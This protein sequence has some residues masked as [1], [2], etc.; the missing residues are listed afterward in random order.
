[1]IYS[2]TGT[3]DGMIFYLANL[4]LSMQF[5][6]L[7]ELDD[8]GIKIDNLNIPIPFEQGVQAYTKSLENSI[9]GLNWQTL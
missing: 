4:F 5:S 7:L 6:E 8:K 3:N 2:V 9:E 1:M